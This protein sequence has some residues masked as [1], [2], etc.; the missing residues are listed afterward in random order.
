MNQPE[1]VPPVQQDKYHN[2][3][4]GLEDLEGVIGRLSQLRLEIAGDQIEENQIEQNIEGAVVPRSLANVLVY[5]PRK[6]VEL[7]SLMEGEMD[8]IRELIF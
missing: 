4:N 2:I 7:I 6:I 5:T 8:S 3:Y 1:C